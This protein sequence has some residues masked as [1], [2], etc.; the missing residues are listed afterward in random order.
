MPLYTRRGQYERN[1]PHF[2]I[3]KSNTSI[4]CVRLHSSV[5]MCREPV[6]PKRPKMIS[7]RVLSVMISRLSVR[8]GGQSGYYASGCSI[9]PP[10]SVQGIEGNPRVP[11][12]CPRLVPCSDTVAVRRVER[13]NVY[14][15][16]SSRFC[17]VVRG[18]RST[19]SLLTH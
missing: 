5:S 1:P 10:I 15:S 12:R 7:S 11:P 3:S 16:W 4:C 17:A 9:Y 14:S 13:E 18:Y 8:L 6:V 19:T 2:L